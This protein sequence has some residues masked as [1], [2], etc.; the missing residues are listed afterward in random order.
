MQT[1]IARAEV[2]PSEC[3]LYFVEN[4]GAEAKFRR[5]EADEMG[6][7]KNWPEKFFGDSLGESK[8][9]TELMIQKLKAQ[10]NAKTD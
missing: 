5:L 3:A 6:R 2:K 8:L 9:Q 7:I 4:E 1:L 10:K